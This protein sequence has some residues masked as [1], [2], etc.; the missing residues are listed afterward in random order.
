MPITSAAI[1]LVI[2]A[3]IFSP[4]GRAAAGHPLSTDDPGTQGARG[5]SVETSASAVL[6]DDPVVICGLTGSAGVS[7]DVDL[8][9]GVSGS[10][11][12]DAGEPTFSLALSLKWRLVS[13]DGCAVGLRLDT[14]PDDLVAGGALL[15]SVGAPLTLLFSIASRAAFGDSGS[16]WAAATSVAL[17]WAYE[18]ITLGAELTAELDG[19]VTP[20][21]SVLVGAAWWVTADHSLSAG[22]GATPPLGNDPTLWSFTLA[23]TVSRA[24]TP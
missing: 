14:S 1:C 2:Q 5:A 16:S 11:G 23:W 21:A 3:F 9:I 19:A 22:L 6:E 17:S 20:H 24:A 7:D 12:I 15:V 18:S 13:R 8:T 10:S 4:P